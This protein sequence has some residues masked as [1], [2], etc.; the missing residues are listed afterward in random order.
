MFIAS[1]CCVIFPGAAFLL[2][3]SIAAVLCWTTPGSAET[4]N[5]GGSGSG[6]GLARKITEAMAHEEPDFSARIMPSLGTTGGL[7]ALSDGAL[8]VAIAARPLTPDEQKKGL[9]EAA[10]FLTPYAFITSASE[11]TGIGQAEIVS[12]Y[13]NSSAI[14]PG[15]MPV[16][17]LLRPM[18]DGSVPYLAN[19]IPGLGAAMSRARERREIPIAT[20]DQDNVEMAMSVPG[21]LTAAPL[22]QLL[23][24]A[25]FLRRLTLDGTVA[26]LETMKTGQY[27]AGLRLC[28]VTSKARSIGADRFIDWLKRS[29]NTE[30]LAR[31]GATLQ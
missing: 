20:T 8:H 19:M 9:V 11:I 23:T 22:T 16:R 27:P 30:F 31:F 26:S 13:E 28:W 14:W 3:I 7:R 15:G 25:P 6:L 10:C 5:I 4:V 17:V 21:S 1:K 29:T 24:E 18:S 2:I 12:F